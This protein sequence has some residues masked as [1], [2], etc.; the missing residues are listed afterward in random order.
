MLNPRQAA[1]TYP[2]T[3]SLTN[4]ARQ[5]EQRALDASM[6]DPGEPAP[7]WPRAEAA[8]WQRDE[9]LEA[10]SNAQAAATCN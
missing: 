1:S 9:A 2:R 6:A 3:E 5:A 10:A 8:E 4:S 7:A